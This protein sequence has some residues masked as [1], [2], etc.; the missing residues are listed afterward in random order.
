MSL[1]IHPRQVVREAVKA[2]IL[3]QNCAEIG[4]R[5]FINRVTKYDLAELPAVNIYQVKESNDGQ[6][7]SPRR[8]RRSQE[9]AVEIIVGMFD[10]LN[11]ER[12]EGQQA[13]NLLD[14]LARVVERALL[15][16]PTVLAGPGGEPV[17]PI[18]DCYLDGT[19]FGRTD[20]GDVVLCSLT[21]TFKIL[22]TEYLF[23]TTPADDW[24]KGV[25]DIVNPET[26]QVLV[27]GVRNL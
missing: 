10:D 1:E 7:T 12:D 16:F 15:T 25:F 19:D 27:T 23:E 9:I 13:F 18:E 4:T 21:Q 2:A 11:Q 17:E 3:A 24:E 20:G 14:S 26:Q 22:F 6:D 8:Y 5:V